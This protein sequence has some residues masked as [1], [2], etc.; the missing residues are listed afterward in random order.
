VSL[1]YVKFGDMRTPNRRAEHGGEARAT[2]GR[3]KFTFIECLTSK[4]PMHGI[5]PRMVHPFEGASLATQAVV[6]DVGPPDSTASVLK[7]NESLGVFK[8][9]L[10]KKPRLSHIFS[11]QLV[12]LAIR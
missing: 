11:T 6:V 4:A 12:I 9:A 5:R 7:L 1:Q 10:R 8:G 2:N 3:E